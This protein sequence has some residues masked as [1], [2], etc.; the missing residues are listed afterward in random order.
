M[1]TPLVALVTD[2]S[3]LVGNKYPMV[4][5]KVVNGWSTAIDS[6]KPSAIMHYIDMLRTAFQVNVY[7]IGSE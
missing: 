1:S 5:E 7:V 2:D 6:I 3:P 4:H